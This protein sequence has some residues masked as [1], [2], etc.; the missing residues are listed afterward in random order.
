MDIELKLMVSASLPKWGVSDNASNIVKALNQSI[1]ELFRCLNHTQQLC[2]IDTMKALKSCEGHTMED[3]ATGCKKLAALKGL[4]GL[5]PQL[6]DIFDNT[7]EEMEEKLGDWK[8]EDHEVM[9]LEE[10]V[11]VSE[12]PDKLTIR[13]ILKRKMKAVKERSSGVS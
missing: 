12:P 7:K 4:Q 11:E 5:H 1:L 2:I 9:E 10:E 8:I 6:L 3:T 13:E